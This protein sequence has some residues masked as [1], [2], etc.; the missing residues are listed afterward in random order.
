[1]ITKNS[2]ATGL[3][4][5][6]FT[7]ETGTAKRRT[8]SKCNGNISNREKQILVIITKIVKIGTSQV[9]G[10]SAILMSEVKDSPQM[11]VVR[12]WWTGE[13]RIK[14][15]LGLVLREYFYEHITEQ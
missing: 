2:L 14:A 4:L 9:C 1:M 7:V 8:V 10:F 11:S 13:G 15:D 5:Y 12:A 3:P 6:R